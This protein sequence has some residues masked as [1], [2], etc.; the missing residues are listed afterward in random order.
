MNFSKKHD[1]GYT[2][3]IVVTKTLFQDT[4][5]NSGSSNGGGRGSSRNNNNNGDYCKLW[6]P[7]D[8][9]PTPGLCML[10]KDDLYIETFR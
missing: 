2:I 5:G 4:Q 6:V 8:G 3:I 10:E 1:V 7:R 9:I